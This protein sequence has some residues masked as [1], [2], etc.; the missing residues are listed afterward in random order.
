[1]TDYL[2]E[3]LS[4]AAI[5]AAMEVHRLLG[6]GFL[7]GVYEQALAVELGLRE[8][9]F[10][11]QVPLTVLYKNVS[12]GDYRPDF[13]VDDRIIIEIKAVSDLA[14]AHESQAHHYLVATG[15]RL[16]ILLNFGARSLQIRRIIR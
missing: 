14:S 13:V 5:G 15:M 8:I 12:V 6:P 2:F 16:A 4:Y 7:E 10:R 9:P 11:R 3:Q 1:M